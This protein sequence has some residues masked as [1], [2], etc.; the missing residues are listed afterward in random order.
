MDAKGLT[1][2]ASIGKSPAAEAFEQLYRKEVQRLGD[3]FLDGEKLEVVEGAGGEPW[4]AFTPKDKFGVALSGG[5][6]RSATFNLGLLQ[7]LAELKVLPNVDYLS[8]V[9]GGGYVGGFWSAWLQ[10]NKNDL[11]PGEPNFPL[12]KEATGEEAAE[13]RHLREFSR[14]LLPRMG[15]FGTEFWAIVMT[16]LGGLLPSLLAA[17][18]VLVLVWSF[19]ITLLTGFF[20]ASQ[21]AWSIAVVSVVLWAG[22]LLM[23][24]LWTSA[25]QNE[26]KKTELSGYLF[27]AALGAVLV[28]CGWRQLVTKFPHFIDAGSATGPVF[29]PALVMG[30]VCVMLLFIRVLLA[31]VS[32]KS[33]TTITDEDDL[34]GFMLAGFERAAMRFLG[35]TFAL[36]ALGFLWWLAG[37]LRDFGWQFKL[38]GSAGAATGLFL[39]LRKWL[40]E[41]VT[42]TK[43]GNLLGWIVGIL[44]R[45]SAKILASIA[46]LL[47]FLLVG[48]GM[49][50]G[51]VAMKTPGDWIFWSLPV[52]GAIV[53]VLMILFF[54]PARIGMHELYR[55]RI[56]RCYLGASNR[57]G[58][59]TG[60]SQAKKA[61]SNRVIGERQG[62]DLTLGKLRETGCNKPLH[63]I[64]TAAN[65][66]SGDTLGTLYRGAQSAVISVHGVSLGGF[67]EA[68]DGLKLSS[69]LTASA[70]AFNSQMGRISMDLGPAVTFLMSAF[71]LRLGLW[72][73]NPKCSGQR[74]LPFPGLLFFAELLGLSRTNWKH[75]LLSD[76]NHFENFGLY[77]LIRRHCRYI[78]VSDCGAD[79]TVVFDD[80]ANVF[81]R[82]RED[83]GVEIELD[84]SRLR[85][86]TDGLASQHAVV[87]TIHYNGLGGVDKGTI[88]FFKAALTGDEPPDVLQYWN[89]NKTF[90]NESTANQFYDEAQWESYR[91]LGEHSGRV[92]LSFLDRPDAPQTNTVDRLF[93]DAR[94]RWHPAPEHLP[95]EFVAMTE[96]CAELEASM[97]TDGPE[98]LRSE[99]FSEALEL[100]KHLPSNPDG[101]KEEL[102]V[103]N[104]LLRGIQVMEDVWV[105]GDFERFWSHPL[106][107]GWMHYFHRWAAT[108]SFRRWWPILSPIYSLEFRQSVQE[109]FAV[110][111]CDPE[112]QRTRIPY[113]PF[114]IVTAELRLNDVTMS[115]AYESTQ[116]WKRFLQMRPQIKAGPTSTQKVFGYC[117]QLLDR[118]GSV[119]R[120]AIYVGF[121]L[122]DETARPANSLEPH[123][124]VAE[125][126]SDEFFVPP[127]FHGGGIVSRLLDAVIHY[128]QTAGARAESGDRRITELQV[129]FGRRPV[130]ASVKK[131][132]MLGPAA[133]YQRVLEIEFY[134]SRRFRYK[135]PE[136]ATGVATLHLDLLRLANPTAPSDK[137]PTSPR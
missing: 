104:F 57:K 112:L 114:P 120:P 102:Q 74:A 34:G 133:R 94:S 75:L 55:S 45:S 92:V 51:F 121:V 103:L 66:M 98:L 32:F 87:G 63:L 130:G 68:Q 91:R 62:D 16:V 96:R 119:A 61:G 5:G 82:I 43:A 84:I 131:S 65:N 2:S 50:W 27:G 135:D 60:D 76:G 59:Q 36:T 46:W 100:T 71:N 12:A 29:A 25:N 70:A 24:W 109:R 28:A 40:T 126:W 48:L 4:I 21:A 128:Y 88:L 118:T 44:K 52:G 54:D 1:P 15:L 115:K 3:E 49:Q 77:E 116:A 72:V 90:P 7:A 37:C 93:L 64:C 35:L 78:I 38:A 33:K 47:L 23:E 107:E 67:T 69:A 41:P 17:L 113:D 85:P 99:F 125:W 56:S 122:V 73:K 117:L 18:A 136:S 42:E 108:P 86:G 111:I 6:I 129:H 22:L 31:R 20:M 26:P 89:W 95:E 134:K 101:L 132:Q 13:V 106:N 10:R 83:F 9:S 124:L 30:A 53:I 58:S 39:W 137:F 11:K 97:A 14:F 81:R 19:W 110:G 123:C 105:A 79:P 80:L 127:T 8:T